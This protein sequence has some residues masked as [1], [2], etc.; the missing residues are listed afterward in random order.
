MINFDSFSNSSDDKRKKQYIDLFFLIMLLQSVL[1]LIFEKPSLSEL[2]TQT[3]NVLL[4]RG[5]M[6]D[7][8]LFMFIARSTTARKQ[9]SCFQV[10]KGEPPKLRNDPPR[11]TFSDSYANFVNMLTIAEAEL[12]PKY[13][14]LLATPYLTNMAARPVDV[15]S[16][17]CTVL[18]SMTEADFMGDSNS[19]DAFRPWNSLSKWFY[20]LQSNKLLLL[21]C[22]FRRFFSF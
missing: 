21:H 9:H 3:F 7:N 17:F 20:S 13:A 22:A 19:D 10:V 6:S 12:R 11:L 2:E 15:A 1:I 8:F 5:P 16:Y 18:N 14:K 4:P